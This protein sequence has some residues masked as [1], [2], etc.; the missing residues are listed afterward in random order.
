M[1]RCARTFYIN[2]I[3][4]L[5][6]GKKRRE[7]ADA[8]AQY[9]L[10]AFGPSQNSSDM[11]CSVQLLALHMAISLRF[12]WRTPC[13]CMFVPMPT[14][15]RRIEP[16]APIFIY[17]TYTCGAGFVVRALVKNN[18]NKRTYHGASCSILWDKNFI[19][20]PSF[21]CR[22]LRIACKS[23]AFPLSRR[24]LCALNIDG[25]T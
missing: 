1:P 25:F 10:D 17:F 22:S 23:A 16:R 20:S 24:A 5:R 12:Q 18:T 15:R 2:S 7:R 9:S 8:G 21:V 14:R 4:P 13:W 11:R 19:R 6:G 3:A